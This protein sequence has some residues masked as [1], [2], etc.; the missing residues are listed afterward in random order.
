MGKLGE[1]G[2]PVLAYTLIK[3]VLIVFADCGSL[4][5]WAMQLLFRITVIVC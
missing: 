1:F 4:G 5:K 3:S 2:N